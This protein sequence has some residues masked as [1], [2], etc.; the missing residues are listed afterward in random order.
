MGSDSANS[1]R[2][3]AAALLA[4][5]GGMNIA[6][7]AALLLASPW[8][9]TRRK[10]RATVWRR[11]GFQRYPKANRSKTDLA[12]LWI[13]A[14]SLGELLS[15]STLLKALPERLEGRPI[16]LSVSTLSGWQMAQERFVND[17]DGLFYFP[18]DLIGS[19]QSC[20]RA[21]R[22]ALFLTVETDL[23]PGFLW[24]LERAGIPAWLVNGRLSPRTFRVYRHLA[25]LF[26]PAL[27]R[28]QS[29]YPQASN[30]A[31]RFRALGVPEHRLG[32]P[33]NLK[34]DTIP[35][36][37][38]R[39]KTQALRRQLPWDPSAPVFLAGST[40]PGEE[41]ALVQGFLEVRRQTTD[42]RFIL[43]PRHPDR[44]RSLASTL[45][46]GGI[47]TALFSELPSG[48]TEAVVIDQFGY[49]A[50]LYA[51]STIAFVGGSLV[52]KGGQ[53]PIEPAAAGVPV[54]CG[55]DMSDFPDITRQLVESGGARKVLGKEDLVGQ[56]SRLL[57]EPEELSRDGE[58]AREVVNRQRGTTERIIQHLAK[59][60][61]SPGKCGSAV[62][63]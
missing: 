2:F 52:P 26:G 7:P 57:L 45:V 61:N 47:Q 13:H 19:V 55:P 31:D 41:A 24:M 22:P 49:L 63:P 23:W 32:S 35:Q 33:G 54:L 56:L 15:A 12:P 50:D 37:S 44:A 16:F 59:T 51:L 8:L 5:Q 4:Y 60:L 30:E 48:N 53:N 14:L 29:I 46:A 58:A 42:L 17:V 20:L 40:H 36:A 38:D 43:A 3:Q 39:Q 11:L 25:P 18:F 27:N 62:F 6:L 28:F 9:L 34:Y 21:I 1:K 10:R